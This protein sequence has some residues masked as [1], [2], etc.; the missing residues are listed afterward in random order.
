M[1]RK[2]R[3]ADRMAH[4]IQELRAELDRE[5]VRRNH[6][7]T[8]AACAEKSLEEARQEHRA[9]RQDAA[10]MAGELGKI[11]AQKIMDAVVPPKQRAFT[12]ANAIYTDA[13]AARKNAEKTLDQA[14]VDLEDAVAREAEALRLLRRAG[15]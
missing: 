12:Q 5:V 11:T 4:E 10:R 7:E 13:V 9:A 2:Q 3:I 14:Q 6:H 15:Q 1:A 8:R